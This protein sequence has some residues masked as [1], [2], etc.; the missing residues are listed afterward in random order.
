MHSPARAIVR[1]ITRRFRWLFGAAAAFLVLASV[2]SHLLPTCWKIQLGNDTVPAVAYV[3][4][5]GSLFVNFMLATAF[6]MSGADSRDLTFSRHM[7]VLPVRTRTLVA[8]PMISG[9]ATVAALWLFI[10]CLVYRPGGIAAPLGWPAAALALFLATIQALCW[11][12]FAQ[13]WLHGVLTVVVLMT[14]LLVLLCGVIFGEALNVRLGEPAAV[15]LLLGLI[16]IAYVAA[17][18]GLERARRGEPYDWRAWGRFVERI[19]QWRPAARHPFHSRSRAQLW[20]EC[21]AHMIVPVFIACLMP[22]FLF[23][24]ALERDEVSL[25]WKLLA[26]LLCVPLMIAMLAGGVLGNLTDAFSR[27]ESASFVLVR[28]ISSL[29]LIKSK[30]VVAAIMTAAIWI[31]FLGYIS[32]L[33]FRPGFPGSIARVAGGVSAWKAVGFPVLLL[34]LLV[35]FTWKNMVESMWVTL[36]GRKWVENASSFGLIG[37]F[38]AGCCVGIWIYFH[39]ELHAAALA[40]V[41]WLI[42]LVLVIKVTAGAFV[43]RGLIR[44]RLAG[45]YGAAVLVAAWAAVVAGLCALAF[46]LLP[47][48]TQARLTSCLPPSSSCRLHAWP[49]RRWR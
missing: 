40:A 11:T 43:L 28:P 30:L 9:C 10:A 12:P 21:R 32:L 24:P 37:L 3:M 41:P 39:P 5:A 1:Q 22:C 29:S 35:G 20:Y 8:W 49:A 33:L 27:S 13:R 46:C 23:V 48:S 31:L 2:L 14:P 19:A 36:T 18:S 44:S 47:A 6:T 45:P 15:G 38:F 4:G 17:V 26:G 25:G 42:G 34:A 16:P 7:F